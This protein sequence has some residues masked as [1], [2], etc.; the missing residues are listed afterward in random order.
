MPILIFDGHCNLCQA[1]VHFILTHEKLPEIR[2][3]A[4][5]SQQGAKLMIK[6]EL[7]FD[8]E[9]SLLLLENGKCLVKSEA[10][11]FVVSYL[12]RPWCWIRFFSFLPNSFRDWIY[13]LVAKNRYHLFGK[14]EQC[15]VPTK[16]LK[17]RF[18]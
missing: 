1:S 16:E 9:R 11:L 10:V 17:N 6:H 18:L 3:V 4:L 7:P 5:Q 14:Q 8:Y 12:K 13:D 15:F 2:F